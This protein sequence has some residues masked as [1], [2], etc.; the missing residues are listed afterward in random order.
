MRRIVL[1]AVLVVAS[2]CTRKFET[3]SK[4]PRLR[5]VDVRGTLASDGGA[6]GQVLATADGIDVVRG[7]I[8]LSVAAEP[9]PPVEKV[10]FF[11]PG[12]PL[13]QVPASDL[14]WDTDTTDIFPVG[15]VMTVSAT[16]IAAGG[17]RG[18][19]IE[20]SFI[21]DNAPPSVTLKSPDPDAVLAPGDTT[22][23]VCAHD[24]RANTP[25]TVTIDAQPT[26]DA[27]AHCYASAP[28]DAEPANGAELV[29]QVE[30][31]DDIGNV[32]RTRLVF[33]VRRALTLG[34][35]GARVVPYANDSEGPVT[36]MQGGLYADVLSPF[37]LR[38]AWALLDGGVL[39]A[40]ASAQ[41]FSVGVPRSSGVAIE[42]TVDPS[43]AVTYLPFTWADA[44]APVTGFTASPSASV[45]FGAGLGA[46]CFA[47]NEISDGGPG[48]LDCFDA[49]GQHTQTSFSLDPAPRQPIGVVVLPNQVVVDSLPLAGTD[50]RPIVER[51]DRQ[52]N[53]ALLSNNR[54]TASFTGCLTNSFGS[55]CDDLAFPRR[56]DAATS[57]LQ[58][59]PLPDSGDP[60][61]DIA[62]VAATP[63]GALFAQANPERARTDLREYFPDGGV[64]PNWGCLPDK[65]DS[66]HVIAVLDDSGQLY[67]AWRSYDQVSFRIRAFSAPGVLS[68]AYE[69][70]VGAPSTVN[71]SFQLALD[72]S[73][74][75]SPLWLV[76]EFTG[77]WVALSR[78]NPPTPLNANAC[79]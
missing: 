39:S 37:G 17:V 67:V 74:P 10:E 52:Q 40:D 13:E 47:P 61:N 30:A 73:D 29:V 12:R 49:L 55:V 9:G 59:L 77:D 58:V 41:T 35:F 51:F 78:R 26:T 48:T 31:D 54:T 21:V 72:G 20:T 75:A 64:G 68:W 15:G 79:P 33:P 11:T 38:H 24:R 1:A 36:A 23:V 27:G 63:A 43:G 69:Q 2:G 8:T 45:P 66:N 65:P 22:I 19:T 50:V 71:P 42:G 57:K 44:G 32:N 60:N 76:D 6:L 14:T 56:L 3:P 16:P 25:V 46:V 53:L 18:N 62:Y 7:S 34:S 70:A 28:L 4:T 5:F